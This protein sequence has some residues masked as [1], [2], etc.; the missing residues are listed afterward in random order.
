MPDIFAASLETF[1][2]DAVHMSW[3]R[4]YST[5]YEFCALHVLTGHTQIVK[6]RKN[7][8]EYLI[9]ANDLKILAKTLNVFAFFI[10]NLNYTDFIFFI[11]NRWLR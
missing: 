6:E 7:M 9:F 3:K 11:Q 1:D 5:N 2:D 8:P 4:K 10:L